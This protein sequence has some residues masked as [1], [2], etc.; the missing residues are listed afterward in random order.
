MIAR[1]FP[2][3][4]TA[5]PDDEYAFVGFPP[6][7]LPPGIEKVFISVL[8][9]WH[10]RE[11]EALREAWA[12]IAPVVVG[13]P[14]YGSSAD[15]FTPGLFVRNG[16][17]IT[18]RGCPNNCWFCAVPSREGHIQELPIRRG[19]NVLDSNLLA[20]SGTHLEKVFSMLSEQDRRPE[21]T[22]GLE[23]KRLTP[24]IAKELRRLKTKQAFFAYDTQDDL[25]PLQIAGEMMLRAGFTRAS[26][27]LRCYVLCGWENDSEE[28]AEKRMIEAMDA[29]FTPMAMV[30][31]DE[32]TGKKKPGWS[33]FQKRWARPAII[34]AKTNS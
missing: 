22:G 26:H 18:S 16:Y 5:T 21:F 34:H 13:G 4:T 20:C 3:R 32:K 29:G 1:V 33:K 23:A 19:W 11:I 25:E 15:D 24:E 27:A 28:K 31:M 12:Y 6:K 30:L 2:T 14:A 7:H 17:T 9:T 10:L 8:F